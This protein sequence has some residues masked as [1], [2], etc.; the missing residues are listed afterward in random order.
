MLKK[1]EG[2]LSGQSSEQGKWRNEFRMKGVTVR[3]GV[4]WKGC[5]GF[6]AKGGQ[7]LASGFEKDHSNME[8]RF[9]WG[10]N[11]QGDQLGVY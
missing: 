4:Y 3:P 6:C 9:C 7:W 5:R 2:D 10:K 8:S 11:K 1:Q